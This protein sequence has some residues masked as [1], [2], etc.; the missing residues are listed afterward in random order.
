MVT[1]VK[2]PRIALGRLG[3]APSASFNNP[4]ATTQGVVLFVKHTS[5]L[6]DIVLTTPYPEAMA[7]IEVRGELGNQLRESNRIATTDRIRLILRGGEREKMEDGPNERP[8]CRITYE[9]KIEGWIRRKGEEREEHFSLGL[10]SKLERHVDKKRKLI[11]QPSSTLLPSRLPLVNLPSAESRIATTAA[12]IPRLAA[13]GFDSST[14]NSRKRKLEDSAHDTQRCP[15]PSPASLVPPTTRT[16][17]AVAPILAST[18]PPP[19]IHKEQLIHRIEISKTQTSRPPP[20]STAL[21]S[22]PIPS[23]ST[24]Q[25]KTQ[26]SSEWD[27]VSSTGQLYT[28]LKSVKDKKVTGSKQFCL[29]VVKTGKLSPPRAGKKDD[30]YCARFFVTDPS[31]DPNSLDHYSST[32]ELQ[33]YERD[34]SKLPTFNPGDVLFVRNLSITLYS[35]LRRYHQTPHPPYLSLPISSLSSSSTL[36]SLESLVFKDSSQLKLSQPEFEHAIKLA[37]FYRGRLLESGKE[38][39]GIEYQLKRLEGQTKPREL[40]LE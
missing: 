20:T 39:E 31:L 29:V 13:L 1:S 12:S 30:P 3:T 25:S 8:R 16:S 14:G 37:K 6:L 10:S 9:G 27:L 33:W 38:G 35:K 5:N 40:D 18:A 36:P 24:T 21:T 4:S 15:S 28:S 32:V 23:T 2:R 7:F 19:V 34:P 11:A 17:R 26:Q 22:L